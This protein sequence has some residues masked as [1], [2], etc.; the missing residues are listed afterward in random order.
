MGAIGHQDSIE[1]LQKYAMD[2]CIV[3]RETCQL[4]L[5]LLEFQSTQ[6]LEPDTCTS[7]YTSVDPAPPAPAKSLSTQQLQTM[8][9]DTSLNLF[10]RY[11]AMFALRDR[12]DVASVEASVCLNLTS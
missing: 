9:L 3:V 5:D 6:S 10:K 8:L 2:E 12:G 7:T 1:I 4:A 11:R